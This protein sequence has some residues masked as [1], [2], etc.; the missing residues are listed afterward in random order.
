VRNPQPPAL[1]T[2]CCPQCTHNVCIQRP[3]IIYPPIICT[4]AAAAA[5]AAQ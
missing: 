4:V 2:C 5:A 3:S 1:P